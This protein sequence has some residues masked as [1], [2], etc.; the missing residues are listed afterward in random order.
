[1]P[2]ADEPLRGAGRARRAVAA[3]VDEA[4]SSVQNY[5]VLFAALHVLSIADVGRFTLAYTAVIL[6]EIVLKSLV[7][8]SLNV[9]F[10]AG[11]ADEQRAAG[12]SAAGATVLAGTAACVVT[13]LFGFVASGA[14]RALLFAT[15]PA[16]L[17]LVAQEAWR[18]Y[19]FTIARPWRAVV[20]DAGC[21][22]FT[23][24]IVWLGVGVAD[25]RSPADLI[26]LLAAG[27]GFGFLFGIVQT[28]IVPSLPGGGAWLRE[29]W[30]AGS[31]VAGSRAVAQ[32]AGRLSLVVLGA[33]SGAAELGR[34]AA[35]RTLIAPVTTL[36]TSMASYSL[37]EA[38]R[39]HRRGDPR[40]RRFLVGNS[41]G[42]A[43]VIVVVGAVLAVLPDPLG[44]V[45]AGT[46]Y[47]T[48]THLLLPVVIYAAGNAL[49]QGAR[50][51]IITLLRSGVALRIAITT[52]VGIVA[53]AAIGAWVDGATGAA[54]GLAIVQ[55][56]QIVTWWSA[57]ARVSVG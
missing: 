30:A 40:L 17:A 55:L 20:N 53:A 47:A 19:F 44:R 15:G 51:G 50:I 52:G 39:L 21:L 48:A 10:A 43:A 35:A 41:V 28:R 11:T 45:L 8:T 54:W 7:L 5:V 1:M 34:Y 33:I 37:P 22:V 29:H 42:L 26:W 57:F 46:N 4:T 13:V 6:V 31:R 2:G 14:D 36:V 38:A 12:A 49:Q 32:L 9:H 16:A 24:V 25:A 27:T 3:L 56:V 23:I 18:S